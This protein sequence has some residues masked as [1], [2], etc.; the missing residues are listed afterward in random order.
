MEC[1]DSILMSDVTMHPALMTLLWSVLAP[2]SACAAEA[3]NPHHKLTALQ[4]AK[5]QRVPACPRTRQVLFMALVAQPFLF[6]MGL[7]LEEI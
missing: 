1:E 6:Q 5:A 4:P 7:I 3:E 2:Q